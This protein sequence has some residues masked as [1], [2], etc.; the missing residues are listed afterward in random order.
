[1][2]NN[3]MIDNFKSAYAQITGKTDLENFSLKD[4]I[5]SASDSTVA[6]YKEQLFGV[7]LGKIYD[8]IAIGNNT[9]YRGKLGDTFYVTKERFGACIEVYDI[10]PPE[11][12]ANPAFNT[13][14][15]GT[16]KIHD[17]TVW[18]PTVKSQLYGKAVSWSIPVAW[19]DVQLNEAFLSESKL[20]TFYD[21]LMLTVR[22]SI[23][24]H[25]ETLIRESL[26]NFIATKIKYASVSGAE[27][28]HVVDLNKA[29]CEFMGGESGT[30]FT[31]EDFRNS[32]KA[33]LYA[34]QLINFYFDDMQEFTTSY[35]V[36]SY[37]RF[38]AP[39][40]IKFIVNSLFDSD[41]KR[42][43]LADSSWD[44]SFMEG[45]SKITLP[46]WQDTKSKDFDNLT[47]INVK[48][49]YDFNADGSHGGTRTE[50]TVS[51]TN[52]VG[53]MLDKRCLM[54]TI[55]DEY[56]GTERDNIKRITL[57]QFE[58]VDR[59]LNN[60]TLNGIIFILSDYT[61]A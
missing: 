3:A 11:I 41:M 47:S 15:S 36:G 57:N 43:A 46:C 29:F 39:N 28:I 13:I 61:F 22:N 40:D 30:T 14:T 31:V 20:M 48:I 25:K 9:E 56:V 34:Q 12:M 7:L 10:I 49:D 19:S 52:V 38:T 53:V 44:K 58:M 21:Y 45:K 2:V 50:A 6:N 60:L 17:N 35:S 16:T 32:P 24:K 55:V 26:N 51:A 4:I 27:G 42:V 18:L 1:M 37:E 33:M 59:Y 8:T 54:H 23:A 5:D